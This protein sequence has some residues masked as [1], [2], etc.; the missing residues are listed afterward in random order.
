MEPLSTQ[1]CL[2]VFLY[3]C[4]TVP[5]SSGLQVLITS[6]NLSVCLFLES[7]QCSVHCRASLSSFQLSS[8]SLPF[9]RCAQLFV[10]N[11]LPWQ[12][13]FAAC[14]PSFSSFPPRLLAFMTPQKLKI[15]CAGLG[16]TGKHHAVY[17]LNCTPR[18][19]LVA[20]ITLVDTEI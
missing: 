14:H 8:L 2:M 3:C 11:T 4:A 9:R 1:C 13:Q 15:A 17:F 20:A 6:Q 19:E 12:Y 18:V 16:R 5:E 10:V 7:V